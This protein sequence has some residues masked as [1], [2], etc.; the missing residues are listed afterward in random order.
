M[1]N[2]TTVLARSNLQRYNTDKVINWTSPIVDTKTTKKQLTGGIRHSIQIAHIKV[3]DNQA[4][5]LVFLNVLVLY[6]PWPLFKTLPQLCLPSFP[7]GTTSPDSCLPPVRRILLITPKEKA[8]LVTN[9]SFH[10]EAIKK[11]FAL[12]YHDQ[13]ATSFI[14]FA[15]RWRPVALVLVQLCIHRWI[16]KTR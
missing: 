6:L 14:H 1:P 3:F 2:L 9:L 7:A 8:E 10:F 15:L 4:P 13:S 5:V 12:S 11:C 16:V